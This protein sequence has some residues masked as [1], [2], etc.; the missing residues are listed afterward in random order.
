MKFCDPMSAQL[1]WTGGFNKFDI[2]VNWFIC[3][4]IATVQ[5]SA[6]HGFKMESCV[7]KQDSAGPTSVW[8]S[9]ASGNEKS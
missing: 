8:V 1:L 6:L 5:F 7:H 2:L 9:I 4:I 3:W